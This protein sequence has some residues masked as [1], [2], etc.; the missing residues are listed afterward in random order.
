LLPRHHHAATSI[1]VCWSPSHTAVASPEYRACSI[2]TPMSVRRSAGHMPMTMEWMDACA[3]CVR[4]PPHTWI[5]RRVAKHAHVLAS[6]KSVS[7]VA[8]S[9]SASGMALVWCTSTRR[10]RASHLDVSASASGMALVWCTST[11]RRKTSHL[12]PSPPLWSRRPSSRYGSV[13]KLL[14]RGSFRTLLLCTL[15]TSQGQLMCAIK[16]SSLKQVAVVEAG[17]RSSRRR[18]T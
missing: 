8:V 3:C 11:R 4:W 5:R 1:V 7:S 12:G 15:I 2:T 9:A 6:P 16:R 13:K 14:C 17:T 18:R 10:R